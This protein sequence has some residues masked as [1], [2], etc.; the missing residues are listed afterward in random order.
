[1]ERSWFCL[2][3]QRKR[4]F[5]FKEIYQRTEQGSAWASQIGRS[6]AT[7]SGFQEE[8]L[9]QILEFTICS[10]HLNFSLRSK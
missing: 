9:D 1:M 2:S 4:E 5:T 8:V 7:F 3:M 10:V 6:F